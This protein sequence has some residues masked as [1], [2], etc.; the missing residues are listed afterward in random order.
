MF[1]DEKDHITSQTIF[2]YGTWE[3]AYISLMAHLIRPGDHVLFLGSSCGIESLIIG[4]LIG[5]RSF[6]GF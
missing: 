5:D 2:R 4:K 1:V 3:P 6:I